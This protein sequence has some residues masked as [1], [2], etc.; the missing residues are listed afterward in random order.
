MLI[1]HRARDK[2]AERATQIVGRDKVRFVSYAEVVYDFVKVE[3][4]KGG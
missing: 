1:L 3:S 2:K 4:N